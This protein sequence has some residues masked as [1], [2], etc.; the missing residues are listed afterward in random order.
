MQ[1]FH[2]RSSSSQ[3]A[4]KARIIIIPIKK[5][6]KLRLRDGQTTVGIQPRCEPFDLKFHIVPTPS[7]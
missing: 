7:L 1:G 3:G 4:Q 2:V 5:V 6:R